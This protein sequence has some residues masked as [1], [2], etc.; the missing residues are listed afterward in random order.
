MIDASVFRVYSGMT[1]NGNIHRIVVAYT[2]EEAI[3]AATKSG[4]VGHP[5]LIAEEVDLDV[6]GVEVGDQD[7]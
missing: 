3:E 5:N 7:V 6:N 2:A 1:G 4:M